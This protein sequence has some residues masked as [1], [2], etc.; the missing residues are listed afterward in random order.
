MKPRSGSLVFDSSSDD[1]ACGRLWGGDGPAVAGS[2]SGQTCVVLPRFSLSAYLSLWTAGGE[3]N[4]DCCRRDRSAFPGP[5][6]DLI[7]ENW[8]VGGKKEEKDHGSARGERSSL[9]RWRCAVGAEIAAVGTAEQSLRLVVFQLIFV[10]AVRQKREE[11]EE[12]E[13]G[14]ESLLLPGLFQG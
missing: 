6:D 3:E 5:S 2:E 10:R 4:V 13:K 11:E 1:T 7:T 9:S 14:A 12:V 8:G